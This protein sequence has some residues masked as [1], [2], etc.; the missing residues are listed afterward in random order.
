MVRI[1]NTAGDDGQSRVFLTNGRSRY[2]VQ[3]R[4]PYGEVTLAPGSYRYELYVSGSA[5]G[6]APDQVGV[7]RCQKYTQYSLEFFRTPFARTRQ[8]DLGDELPDPR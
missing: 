8:E 2:R 5:M 7:L 4:N 1:Y 6:P 3:I